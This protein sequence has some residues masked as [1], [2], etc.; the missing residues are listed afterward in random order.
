MKKKHVIC[1]NDPTFS[2]A[3]ILVGVKVFC[4]IG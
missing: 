2:E 4:Y 3:K 1:V